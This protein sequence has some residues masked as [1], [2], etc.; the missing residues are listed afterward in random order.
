[1]VLRYATNL[2]LAK[3]LYDASKPKLKRR[4]RYD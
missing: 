1:M 4:S 3:E 2:K